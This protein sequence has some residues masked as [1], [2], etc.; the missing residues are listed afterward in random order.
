V[1]TAFLNIP[2]NLNIGIRNNILYADMYSDLLSIDIS[3]VQQPKLV[4]MVHNFFTSRA[5]TSDSSYI[6]S[7]WNRKD[8]SFAVKPDQ[9][10]IELPIGGIYVPGVVYPAAYEAFN[11]SGNKSG[12]GVAG[13]NAVMVM[14]GDYLYGIP[15]EH[16]LGIVD[17]RD[18]SK[19]QQALSF[20]AGYD[21]ETI[22]LLQD[23]LLLGSKEGVYVYSITNPV[24]PTKLGE[25]THGT[26]CDPVIANSKYAYVTLHSGSYC[27]GAAN[28]LDI[29]DATDLTNATQIKSYPMTSPSGLGVDGTTL[30]VCD[31]SEV[32]IYNVSDPTNIQ[33]LSSLKVED[34]NDVIVGDHLLLVVA[35]DGLHEFDYTDAA[36][37]VKLG[38]FSINNSKS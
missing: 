31:A 8:T 2:G 13:S 38:V 27:G 9:R 10:L 35:N 29:L 30:F 14:S 15:E 37:P 6:I 4:G 16:T 24:S 20:M 21:L 22:F 32:K 17:V 18:S 5:Y 12:T 1:Q 11:S 26:A 7:G 25:F 3:N 34:A 36:H 19:P 33:L 28:E 23:K